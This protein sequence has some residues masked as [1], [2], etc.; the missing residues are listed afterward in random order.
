MRTFFEEANAPTIGQAHERA[1]KGAETDAT[2]RAL[3]TFGNPF[4]LALYDREKAGVRQRPSKPLTDQ[5]ANGPW[6]LRSS[7]GEP[8]T[9]FDNAARFGDALRQTMTKAESIELLF[10]IWEQ[11][12]ATVRALSYSLKQNGKLKTDFGKSLVAHL[13]SCAIALVNP[14]PA[15][16]RNEVKAG[17]VKTGCEKNGSS[18]AAEK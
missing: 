6:I 2:K 1:L 16:E 12:L 15:L 7:T 9:T 5:L 3:A 11:N 4:G 18:A 13:K 10:A 17:K 8:T 14:E